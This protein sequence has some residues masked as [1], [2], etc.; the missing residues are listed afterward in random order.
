MNSEIVLKK[1]TKE[2]N[3]I[4]YQFDCSEDLRNYFCFDEEFFIE[5]SNTNIGMVPDSILAVP[6]LCNVLPIVWILDITICID[7][8]D[9]A[10]YES[11]PMFKNG[12]VNMYSFLDFKGKIVVDKIIDNDNSEADG[13]NLMFF[14][15]GVD[16]FNT[17][18]DLF[19][20]REK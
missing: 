7:E 12:Y 18:I 2:N 3:K 16:S 19:D 13:Q 10:F 4:V 5:Y 1:I 14:S 9:R 6:F 17:L 11:I 8:I 20:N 15:G